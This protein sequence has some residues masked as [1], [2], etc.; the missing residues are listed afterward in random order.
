M[1]L[2]GGSTRTF[3]AYGKR[4]THTI[5]RTT[6]ALWDDE[7]KPVTK[8]SVPQKTTP[9]IALSSSEESDDDDDDTDYDELPKPSGKP[10]LPLKSRSNVKYQSRAKRTLVSS[11]ALRRAGVPPPSDKENLVPTVAIAAALTTARKASTQ[12]VHIVSSPRKPIR[13]LQVRPATPLGSPRKTSPPTKKLAVR[14]DPAVPSKSSK[15]A[16]S[17]LQFDGVHVPIRH[18]L[19]ATSSRVVPTP[20]PSIRSLSARSPIVLSSEEEDASVEFY[21]SFGSL[22]LNKSRTLVLEDEGREED[23]TTTD[24]SSRSLPSISQRPEISKTTSA[25]PSFLNE[26]MSITATPVPYDFTSFVTSPPSPFSIS[27]GTKWTKIGEASYSEVFASEGEEGEQMVIKIIPVS[28]IEAAAGVPDPNMGNHLPFVSDWTAVQREI[29]ASALVGEGD[30]GIEGF[31]EYKG[32]FIVQG[33]YPSRLLS[34]WDL[35]RRRLKKERRTDYDSQIR[36]SVLPDRQVY[37]IICLVH[38]GTDLESF[39][40]KSWKDAASVL[41]QAAQACARGEEKVEFE[42]RDLHWGNLLVKPLQNATSPCLALDFGALSLTSDSISAPLDARQTGL[43]VTLIDFTLSRAKSSDGF[44]IFDAFD[45]EEVFEGQGDPQFDVYRTMRRLIS[46]DWEGFHPITNLHWL[47]YL[48]LKLLHAKKLRRP[49]SGKSMSIA[50]AAEERRWYET[51]V[52]LEAS[53]RSQVVE[54]PLKGKK[55][56]STPRW[57]NAQDLVQVW[58]GAYTLDP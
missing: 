52:Q 29:W 28:N 6:H 48:S 45:D 34:E 56:K 33:P 8:A 57:T 35:Y 3:K 27:A 25:Y 37:A 15:F 49:V 36:P 17:N 26:L 30:H 2:L 5:N 16:Q 13:P 50:R 53:L 41:W 54:V 19:K 1:T 38:A 10:S 32:A 39:K 7:E 43:Q 31:V 42:H 44:V 20:R 24:A 21:N 18:V 22:S 4:K 9:S 23:R 58:K 46:D 14:P 11:V 12:A 40:L 55:I 51:L 47:H